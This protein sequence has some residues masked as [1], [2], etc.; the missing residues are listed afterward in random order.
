MQ[1]NRAHDEGC[2]PHMQLPDEPAERHFFGDK[3]HAAVGGGSAGFVIKQQQHAGAELHG[4][5]QQRG[6]AQSVQPVDVARL[7]FGELF[8][9]KAAEK[10]EGKPFSKPGF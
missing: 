10:I 8:V 2:A 6:E 1:K 5:Q 3:L 9:G 4:K 7:R